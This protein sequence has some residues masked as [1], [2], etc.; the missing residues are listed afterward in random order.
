MAGIESEMFFLSTPTSF[1]AIR[2]SKLVARPGYI[3]IASGLIEVAVVAGIKPADRLYECWVLK[4]S[5]GEQRLSPVDRNPEL[6]PGSKVIMTKHQWDKLDPY[7]KIFIES[8]D[9]VK[10]EKKK[11]KDRDCP[12]GCKDTDI[13][14][15]FARMDFPV[16]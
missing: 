14:N 13:D 9:K 1:A 3:P 16:R 8:T 10:P 15:L 11:K 4:S 7:S 6:S 2:P 5:D 12:C